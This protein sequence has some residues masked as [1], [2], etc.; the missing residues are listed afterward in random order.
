MM[1]CVAPFQ[2][3]QGLFTKCVVCRVAFKGALVPLIMQQ[4]KALGRSGRHRRFFR[5]S[6]AMCDLLHQAF[7]ALLHPALPRTL[8]VSESEN[9]VHHRGTQASFRDDKAP[10]VGLVF[11]SQSLLF[12][13]WHQ[14]ALGTI[15]C[16]G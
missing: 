5:K 4:L 7:E 15:R 6:S 11:E 10:V 16:F 14:S 9:I 3:Q 1:R 12:K 2:L 8:S 13:N